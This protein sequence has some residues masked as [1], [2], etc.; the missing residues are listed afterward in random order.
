M[1]DRK[2]P[3]D[4]V[5]RLN[6]TVYEEESSP[7]LS[8]GVEGD[9][10]CADADGSTSESSFGVAVSAMSHKPM[11]L[12]KMVKLNPVDRQGWCSAKKFVRPQPGCERED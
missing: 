1:R 4:Y 10:E 5:M 12:S 3:D 6:A 8:G 9:R 11:D 2:W 7:I